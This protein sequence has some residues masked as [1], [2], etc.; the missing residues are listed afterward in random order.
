MQ[1]NRLEYLILILTAALLSTML[2]TSS[3]RPLSLSILIPLGL[4]AIV[5]S[6]GSILSINKIQ[7]ATA[8]LVVLTLVLILFSVLKR[9]L[10]ASFYQGSAKSLMNE[11]WL[12]IVTI[13]VL[14]GL[15]ALF[16]ARVK[17]PYVDRSRLLFLFLRVSWF[18]GTILTLLLEFVS[19]ARHGRVYSKFVTLI[20]VLVSAAGVIGALRRRRPWR[21][22]RDASLLELDRENTII[23]KS[24]RPR[25]SESESQSF[26]PLAF[27][28]ILLLLIFGLPVVASTHSIA[29]P[30]FFL[31]LYVALEIAAIYYYSQT[32][33]AALRT[34][35]E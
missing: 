27:V 7:R 10:P 25:Y 2:L 26:A 34:M 31:G 1:T 13:S 3:Q 35:R 22:K 16:F 33:H 9:W 11:R 18:V 21:M 5:F 28:R 14:C 6:F 15:F 8:S 23:F 12:P 19:L 30:L 29:W 20:L 17:R 4:A 32:R 24:N